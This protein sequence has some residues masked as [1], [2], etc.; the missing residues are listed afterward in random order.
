MSTG[1]KPAPPPVVLQFLSTEYLQE[2]RM[3]L[4]RLKHSAPLSYVKQASEI[5]TAPV[6]TFMLSLFSPWNLI[7]LF[8]PR[9]YVKTGQISC[10]VLCLFFFLACAAFLIRAHIKD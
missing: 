7:T 4:S 8:F 10:H 3:Y 6:L 9:A 5:V 2:G 1:L